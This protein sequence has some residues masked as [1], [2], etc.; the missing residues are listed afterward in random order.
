[1]IPV[2]IEYKPIPFLGFKRRIETTL[3]AHWSELTPEQLILIPSVFNDTISE[4]HILQVFLNIRWSIARRLDSYYRYCLIRNLKYLNE[5]DRCDR[6]IIPNI[7][8]YKAPE[9]RL[10]GVT[11]GA[12]IFGDTYFQNYMEGKKADLDKFIACY[13]L[14]G[15]FKDNEID[16]RAARLSR[17]SIELREAI[18]LN[19][20]L[21]REW[22][23]ESY[24]YVFQKPDSKDKK[25]SKGS[26][27]KVFDM[28]VGDD[29][30]N[31]ER[32]AEQP[33]SIILRYLNQKAKEHLKGKS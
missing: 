16:V 5:L 21:I 4:T 27:V 18:I 28:V 25:T 1:M 24:P 32:Y 20:K 26:W 31:Q 17:E 19:Y 15:T 8:R 29:I 22:L 13:Y 6:F 7:G 23:A 14:D 11:F 2:V 33:L 9:P 10:K 30:V 3:P 12:F